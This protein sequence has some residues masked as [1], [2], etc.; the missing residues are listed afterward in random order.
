MSTIQITRKDAEVIHRMLVEFFHANN[1]SPEET[2][3][4]MNLSSAGNFGRPV[5]KTRTG[6]A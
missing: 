4:L 1:L 6:V 3:A 5:L 2:T